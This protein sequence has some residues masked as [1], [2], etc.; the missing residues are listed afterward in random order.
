MTRLG[1]IGFG[2]LGSFYANMINREHRVD[3][4]TV[5]AICDIDPERLALARSLYPDAHLYDSADK[6][7]KDKKCDFVSVAVP[8]YA[9]PEIG[10][11]CLELGMPVL[12]EKPAGII[13]KT[14]RELNECALRHKDVPFGIM[15]NQRTNPIF[16]R[17]HQL[18]LS[19][20]MGSL[21]QFTWLS[22]QFRTQHYY[23]SGSWRATWGG[24]G[25]GVL[26][27]QAPHQID[28]IQ[29]MFGMPSSVFATANVGFHR[30]IAVENDVCA[31][32]VYPNNATG[33]FIT[34]TDDILGEN[35]LT[36]IYDKGRVRVLNNSR[37]EIER[38]CDDE[39]SLG[40]NYTDAELEDLRK[41]GKLFETEI[42]ENEKDPF[43]NSEH[44]KVFR[45]FADHLANPSKPLVAEGVDGLNEV[46]LAGAIQLSGWLRRP[47][48]IPAD[49]D[50]YLAELNSLIEREGKYPKR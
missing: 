37:M 24:E 2:A 40:T 9:H 47:V 7:L 6:L 4:L 3:G 11:E 25:G 49:D 15:L 45:A 38:L 33:V 32:F 39:E 23:D 12:L 29:W 20:K 28:L 22:R 10:I 46:V 13:P 8:H 31:Q 21:R 14:V 5:T 44:A 35:R 16:R 18:T 27:N 36:A 48:D 17:L 43:A 26:V 1:I 41:S 42:I 50:L 19:G 34:C 30:N